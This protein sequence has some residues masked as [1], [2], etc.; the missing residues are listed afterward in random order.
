MQLTVAG[1]IR[2]IFIEYGILMLLGIVWPIAYYNS[3]AAPATDMPVELLLVPM[4]A[5][6]FAFVAVC[7]ALMRRALKPIPDRELATRQSL[8]AV[9]W[10]PLSCVLLTILTPVMSVVRVALA[11]ILPF[12]IPA[13]AGI[14]M[15]LLAA[16]A[17]F[18]LLF[19]QTKRWHL[20]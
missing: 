13:E 19:W 15:V 6:F 16:A 8:K 2:F 4:T 11:F 18:G 9:L 14:A 5:L 17:P 1:L 10:A 20:D 7:F 3:P 12:G